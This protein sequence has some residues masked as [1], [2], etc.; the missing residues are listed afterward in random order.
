MKLIEGNRS[1]I[2]NAETYFADGEFTYKLEPDFAKVPDGLAAAGFPNGCCD[3]EGNIY[4]VCRDNDHPIVQ[5][6]SSG[7]Y[8][9][10]FGK[11]LFKVIH[12]IK[13][14]PTGTLLC[15]DDALHVARELTMDGELIRD[16]GT[17]GVPS[18]TGF[19][20]HIWKKLRQQGR[21]A[22]YDSYDNPGLEFVEKMR[23]IKRTAPPFNKP[24]GVAFN[25]KG[26][27]FFSDGYGNA[28]VHKFNAEGIFVKTWGEPGEGPGKFLIN[29]A[30]WVDSYDRIWIA[31]R[32]GSSVHIFS[33]EGELLGYAAECFYQPSNVWGD[34][35]F[36][37]VGERGG[38]LSIFDMNMDIVAQ[39]GFPFSSLRCHGLCGN[40]NHELFFFTLHSFPGYPIMKLT[41]TRE[42]SKR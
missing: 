16:F 32:E 9:R 40:H 30:I 33:D 13:I 29:H 28:A 15:V 35:D 2:Q 37:Y 5:L 41:R 31:D 17:M 24:T 22:T 10:D 6:D 21:L 34:E 18:D 19:D 14:T 7:R 3:K 23:T 42:P 12:D 1:R 25:S 4:A 20:P 8:I 38:G 36:V 26:E 11:G 27:M 39:L